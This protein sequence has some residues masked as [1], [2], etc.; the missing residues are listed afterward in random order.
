M[1]AGWTLSPEDAVV[2]AEVLRLVRNALGN[3]AVR[4]DGNVNQ[5][6]FYDELDEQFRQAQVDAA[7]EAG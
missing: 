5:R 3:C 7:G 1:S 4:A 6:D 2:V